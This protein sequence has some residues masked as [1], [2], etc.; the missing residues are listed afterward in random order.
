MFHFIAK[1]EESEMSINCDKQIHLRIVLDS[2][3]SYMED[4]YTGSK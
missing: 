1:N 4:V 3:H 2:L